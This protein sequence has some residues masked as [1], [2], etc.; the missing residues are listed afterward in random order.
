MFELL[1]SDRENI[2]QF[3]GFLA[4]IKT[5]E[6]EVNYIKKKL[7]G[8]ADGT[9]AF[10][11]IIRDDHIVG[12]INLHFIDSENK[13]TYIGYWLHSKFHHQGIMTKS[14]RKVCEYTF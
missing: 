5:E 2:S 10:F 6:D 1:N 14:V 12:V 3:F 13:K 4:S 9:D 11:S 8:I 7:H